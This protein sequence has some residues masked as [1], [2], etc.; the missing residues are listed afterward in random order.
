M[1]GCIFLR[2][3]F[4]KNSIKGVLVSILSSAVLLLLFGWICFSRA[5]PSALTGILG[6]AALY[7]SAF[8]GGFFAARFNRETGLLSGLLTGGIFMLF[9]IMLSLFLRG[10]SEPMGFMTW[11]MF[12]L[13]ALLG[14]VGGYLGTPNG[15]KR[16][17][18]K[19]RK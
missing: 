7:I 5:D 8:L 12:L 19:R 14:G 16:K 9:V 10:G 11:I 3:D 2:G 1:K 4:F 6:R 15:K 17:R 13:V 18:R